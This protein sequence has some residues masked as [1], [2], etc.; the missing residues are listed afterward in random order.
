ME[1]HIS[2]EGRQLTFDEPREVVIGRDPDSDVWVSD[3]RVSRRHAV[4]RQTARGWELVDI[5]ST[6]GTY[7]G[8]RRVSTLLVGP[9]TEV[10][11]GNPDGPRL[12]L[13][14]PSA[15]SAPPG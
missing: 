2:C 12:L 5:I 3:D 4:V 6:N 11:L 13:A 15:G 7:S 8:G 9:A 14:A 10:R 1:L